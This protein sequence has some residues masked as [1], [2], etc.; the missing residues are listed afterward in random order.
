MC[1]VRGGGGRRGEE[2]VKGS[3]I[4]NSDIKPKRTVVTFFLVLSRLIF[5]GM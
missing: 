5:F 3:D 4:N 1:A 2:R